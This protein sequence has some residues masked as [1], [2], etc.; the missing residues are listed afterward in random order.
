MRKGYTLIELTIVMALLL[1]VGTIIVGIISSALRGN[2]K[3]KITTDIAQN[4]NYAI[5]VMSDLITNSQKLNSLTGYP[6]P[7]VYPSCPMSPG[8]L[9]KSL[10]IT[11]L[12]GGITI[13]ACDDSRHTITSNS[14]SL[15][16]TTQVILSSDPNTSCSITCT[17]TDIYSS[18]RI[19]IKFQLQ[20][21]TGATS[22]KSA[23]A[24]FNT[25]VFLRNQGLK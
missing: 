10:S 8:V 17:Q 20:N 4:G 5:S 11:G 15:L 14:A 1:I 24:N 6:S 19:D 23:S 12:D 13:F 22:E 9:G 16:D 3:T 25:S 21:A 18:P 7:T 2:T